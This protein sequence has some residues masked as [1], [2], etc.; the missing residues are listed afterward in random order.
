MMYGWRSRETATRMLYGSRRCRNG[1][2]QANALGIRRTEEVK[3]VPVTSGSV[4]D[5]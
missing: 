3:V 5:V 1:Y 4:G 2:D